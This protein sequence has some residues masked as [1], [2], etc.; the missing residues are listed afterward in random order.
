MYIFTPSPQKDYSTLL[1]LLQPVAGH[2]IPAK[3]AELTKDQIQ[4]FLI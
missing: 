3:K 2:G 4:S 1:V